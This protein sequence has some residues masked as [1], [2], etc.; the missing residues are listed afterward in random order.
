MPFYQVDEGQSGPRFV[1][2]TVNLAPADQSL[3]QQ[4]RIPFGFI[5]QPLA[6]LTQGEHQF[7]EDGTNGVVPEISVTQPTQA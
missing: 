6:E 1:K 3:Q 2:C 5:V 7:A 4:S